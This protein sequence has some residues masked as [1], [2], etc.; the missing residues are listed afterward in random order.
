MLG[1]TRRTRRGPAGHSGRAINFLSRRDNGIFPGTAGKKRLTA[2]GEGAYGSLQVPFEPDSRC[3]GI[4]WI[5]IL[6]VT[7][8]PFTPRKT[9]LVSVPILS[10]GTRLAFGPEGA[11]QYSP[12]Q[13]EAATAAQAPPWVTETPV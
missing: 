7:F 11:R 3:R 13:S 6:T 12:G 8:S 5:Q 9:V 1:K 10:F 2:L 4:I